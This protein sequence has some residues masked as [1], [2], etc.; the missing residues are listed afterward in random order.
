MSVSSVL[1]LLVCVCR[2]LE[3]LDVSGN[4]IG[5]D[6]ATFIARALG[7]SGYVEWCVMGLVVHFGSANS[8]V[9]PV[10]VGGECTLYRYIQICGES[11]AVVERC[12]RGR[13]SVL[14]CAHDIAL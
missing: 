6:G 14:R 8:I 1:T 13:C 11:S 12:C 10:T 7:A 3:A 5:P 2:S 4:K 9:V